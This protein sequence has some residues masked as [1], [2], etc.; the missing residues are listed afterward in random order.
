MAEIR[1]MT[2]ADYDAVSALWRR[3]EG[4]AQNES[5]AAEAIA[6]FLRRNPDM[7]SVAV[8]DADAIVGAV[9]C[10]TDGRRGYLHHLAVE[11]AERKRGVATHLL[12]R[13]FGEL[14]RAGIPKCNLFLFDDNAD[15]AVFW[16]R[17]GWIERSDLRVFQKG[18]LPGVRAVLG[19]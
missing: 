11:R 13:C 15:G 12:A 6:A 10:G 2:M 19:S 9:L 14:A 1:A 4:V 17:A 7:S 18:V 8:G 3:T 5:D 16:E